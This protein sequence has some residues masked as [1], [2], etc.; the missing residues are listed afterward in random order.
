MVVAVSAGVLVAL[1][2]R[3]PARGRLAAA[4]P[5]IV[6]A[7]ATAVL[8]VPVA[9]EAAASRWDGTITSAIDGPAIDAQ[10]TVASAAR[11]RSDPD[12]LLLDATV[13]GWRPA[14][15][16]E[17]CPPWQAARAPVVISVPATA[18]PVS[19]DDRIEITGT[20]RA[21]DG[22]QQIAALWDAEITGDPVPSDAP[23]RALAR[24]FVEATGHL[25]QHTRGLVI[26]MAS[27]DTAAM[28]D[29][30]E[31]A[32]R[33]SGLAHL[34]AVSGAHFAVLT[35]AV[36][37]VLRQVP[38][39]RWVRGAS[40][41]VVATGFAVFVG[42]E[43]SVLR[44]MGMATAV[45]LALVWGRPAR[46]LPALAVTVIVL[47]VMDPWVSVSIGFAMSVA[48]VLAIVLVAAP[49]A[50]LLSRVVT[51]SAARL[52]SIPIVAHAAVAPLIATFTPGVSAYSVLANAMAAPVVL[53]LTV[54]G[55]ITA[56]VSGVSVTAA[57]PLASAAGW[58]AEPLAAIAAGVTQ[59]SGAWISVPEAPWGAIVL[60]VLAGGA[61][62]TARARAPWM[63]GTGVLVMAIVVA[64]VITDASRYKPPPQWAAVSCDVGQG[65]MM[66]VRSD[67]D[68]AVVIDTGAPAQ[69]AA[70]CLHRFGIRRVPL[71]V[72][73]HPHDDHDGAVAEVI[74]AAQVDQ[75]W[76]SAHAPPGAA[77]ATLDD[78]DVPWQVPAMGAQFI[79]ER[80]HVTVL[81]SWHDRAWTDVNDGSIVVLARTADI[82]VLGLGDLEP[83]GQRHL[84][85]QLGEIT[86]DAVK[87]AHHGS[88]AQD[89]DL[90][91]S[92]QAAVALFSVG[93]NRHGHPA[94]ET[95]DLYG[96]SSQVRRT[97]LCGD[98]VLWREGDAVAV[99]PECQPD[100][101]P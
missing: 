88:R 82:T 23:H 85:Q 92:I 8:V 50:R 83:A 84:L 61:V 66:L 76:V 98:V 89:D 29:A 47:M 7:I 14:C 65:D 11:Q 3:P 45:A 54:T 58:M 43:P 97:D 59:L 24:R 28:P 99:W 77:V 48:A 26:G 71:L 72:L 70:D 68:A 13:D 30:Q 17:P 94:A 4:L 75:A 9:A 64:I 101:A 73:T 41:L 31:H 27:G 56:L 39:A 16:D 46:A 19:R 36:V 32:M 2:R 91:H 81:S 10:V 35:L 86:V 57:R 51:P 93:D 5:S 15:P 18:T 80:A 25:P 34:T 38:V 90:A 53:P 100:M 1:S 67:V 60:A 69:G 22:G 21:L 33:V 20:A 79:S 63:R 96:S 44:A 6:V 40:V 74:A 95:L 49:V 62:T 52:A 55:V 12:R 37:T 87:V 78:H 42:P